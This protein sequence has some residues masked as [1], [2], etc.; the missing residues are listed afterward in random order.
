MYYLKAIL[1]EN[2]FYSNNARNLLE[3][4]NFE[5]DIVDVSQDEKSKWKTFELKTFPQI[6][7]KKYNSKNNLYI[8]GFDDLSY[9]ESQIKSVNKNNFSKIKENIMNKYTKLS[10]K[11]VLR[12]ME[13]FI[14]N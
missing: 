2:C 11:S 7:L 6:F 13:L 4:Y 12:L 14:K 1:L 10:E 9:I 8:G 3:K 5:K